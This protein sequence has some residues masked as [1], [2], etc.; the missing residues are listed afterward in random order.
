M[1]H[2]RKRV[3]LHGDDGNDERAAGDGV[4]AVWDAQFTGALYFLNNTTYDLGSP[5]VT[6]TLEDRIG[7]GLGYTTP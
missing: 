5:V 1:V 2:L 7:M 4:V 6:G 3:H